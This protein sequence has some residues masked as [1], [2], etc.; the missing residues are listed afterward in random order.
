MTRPGPRLFVVTP[1][2]TEPLSELRANHESVLRQVVP[3]R[4][5]MVADGHPRPEIDGWD[6]DHITLPNHG[7]WGD[8]PRAIG[9]LSAFTRGAEGLCWLDA[10]NWLREDHV[11][12]MEDMARQ[13]GAPVITASRTIHRVDGSL[14][15]PDPES[16][17]EQHV[18]LNCY[19]LR[20]KALRLIPYFA[21]KPS[22][23]SWA[24]DRLLLQMIKA[25]GLQRAHVKKPTVC[26]RT[27]YAVHYR[28][29]GEPPPPDAKENR[30]T[31]ERAWWDAQPPEVQAEWRQYL[32]RGF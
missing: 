18:D 8:T 27:R 22:P 17:G 3:V 14:M 29:L 16:D 13:T 10:D 32:N 21:I 30:G 9:G 2:Y 20:G 23:L 19:Y 4:H 12:R 7:D 15:Y 31:E 24:F 1:Y 5:I 11:A 25:R 28:V 26:Y 6:C